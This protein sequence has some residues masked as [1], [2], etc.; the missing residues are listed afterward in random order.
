MKLL[1]AVSMVMMVGCSTQLLAG[2]PSAPPASQPDP[3]FIA[4]AMFSGVE[5]ESAPRV[6]W[7]DGCVLTV[8]EEQTQENRTGIKDDSGC[9][10][11]IVGVSGWMEVQSA[12]KPSDSSLVPAMAAWRSWLLNTN[13]VNTPDLE[14]QALARAALQEAGL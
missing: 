2:A 13:F 1:I 12:D 14:E 5:A 8:P 3:V 10:I 7:L 4:W 11:Y 6:H 9:I